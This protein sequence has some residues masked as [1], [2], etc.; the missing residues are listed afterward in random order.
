MQIKNYSDFPF[1]YYIAFPLAMPNFTKR[2]LVRDKFNPEFLFNRIY[3]VDGVRYHVSVM[4]ADR[5]VFAF[6]MEEKYGRWKIINAPKIP[7]WIMNIEKELEDAI[8]EN[9]IR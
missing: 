2:I 1:P 6:N 4:D 9:L 5:H 8:F 3:T 7:D